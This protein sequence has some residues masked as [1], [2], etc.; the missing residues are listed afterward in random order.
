MLGI[1]G[2]IFGLFYTLAFSEINIILVLLGFVLL[3][4]GIW[5]RVKPTASSLIFAGIALCI[6]GAWNAVTFVLNIIAFVADPGSGAFG[7]F[8][9][10]IWAAVLIGMGIEAFNRYRR[11]QTSLL[12]DF[13][14]EELQRVEDIAKPVMRADPKKEDDVFLFTKPGTW[15]SS[16]WKGKLTRPYGVIASQSG[17]DIFIVSPEEVN[18][19][20]KGKFRLTKLRKVSLTIK[21]TKF[22]GAMPPESITR[23]QYWKNPTRVISV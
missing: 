21:G 17:D 18:V 9:G 13:T 4:I 19:E 15:T 22:D 23:I 2:I 3:G 16:I 20:D 10:A 11:V 6:M 7:I 5:A 1:V 12:K 14:K 8:P